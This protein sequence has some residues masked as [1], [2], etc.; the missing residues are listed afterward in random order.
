MHG[1]CCLSQAPLGIDS[2][3]FEVMDTD[4]ATC[5]GTVAKCHARC[6]AGPVETG[7]VQFFRLAA[8]HH[9]HPLRGHTADVVQQCCFA[10]PGFD[11]AGLQHPADFPTTRFINIPCRGRQVASGGNADDQAFRLN[12]PGRFLNQAEFHKMTSF[13]YRMLP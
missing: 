4:M 7:L 2:P 13:I 1:Q 12:E 8:A 3:E 9:E 11:I 10:Q 5:E 6:Q